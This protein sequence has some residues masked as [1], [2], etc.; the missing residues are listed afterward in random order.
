MTPSDDI[1]TAI[2]SVLP[3]YKPSAFYD[4]SY[5]P[6][7]TTGNQI[8][9]C[10][11]SGGESVSGLYDLPTVDVWIF[12]KANAHALRDVPQLKQDALKAYRFLSDRDNQ[13]ALNAILRG[14]LNSCI[15][16]VDGLISPSDI[17]TTG[18][19]RFYIKFTVK[20]HRG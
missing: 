12:S 20:L 19:N 9:F 14:S 2:L 16:A 10:K 8:V 6:F 4:E 7:K 5:E 13:D 3:D 15:F 17:Y 18:Q 1:R 11:Q